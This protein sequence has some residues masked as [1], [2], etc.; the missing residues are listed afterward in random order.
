VVAAVVDRSLA[1][2]WPADRPCHGERG[3]RDEKETERRERK[4]R[5]KER[6]EERV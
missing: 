5:E 2:V 3:M 1:A 6:D 4:E